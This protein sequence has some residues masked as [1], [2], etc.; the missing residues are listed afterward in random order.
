MKHLKQIATG[1]CMVY[2]LSFVSAYAQ[3]AEDVLMKSESLLLEEERQLKVNRRV[4]EIISSFEDLIRDLRSNGLVKEARGDELLRLLGL[5]GTTNT[6]NVLAAAEHLRGARQNLANPVKFLGSADTEIEII[7]AKL[8]SVLQ[9]S[10]SLQKT[11]ELLNQIRRIIRNQE[12]VYAKSKFIG[13]QLLIGERTTR[14]WDLTKGQLQV[15]MSVKRFGANLAAAKK[16]AKEPLNRLRL[17]RALAVMNREKLDRKLLD[18]TRKIKTKRVVSA[19]RI[20]E[21]ALVSLK[22]IERRLQ[23]NAES[24]ELHRLK[25]AR[26]KLLRIREDQHTIQGETRKATA[27]AFPER[28]KDL[29]VNQRQLQH[30]LKDLHTSIP[31]TK[32]EKL[33]PN[34]HRNTPLDKSLDNAHATM[35]TSEK[36]IEETKQTEAVASQVETDQH[37]GEALLLLDER[38][39]R[40]QEEAL[41]DPTLVDRLREIEQYEKEILDETQVRQKENANVAEIAPAQKKLQEY[42]LELDG[43]I[44]DDALKRVISLS[45]DAMVRAAVSLAANEHDKAI[46]NEKETLTLLARAIEM[47]IELEKE[48]EEVETQEEEFAQEEQAIEQEMDQAEDLID[49]LLAIERL[50]REL[51]EDTEAADANVPE[52]RDLAEPQNDLAKETQR[53][54]ELTDSVP[55]LSAIDD[56]ALAM[57]EAIEKIRESEKELAHAAQLKALEALRKARE[58]AEEKL[59]DLELERDQMQRVDDAHEMAAALKE[60]ERLQKELTIETKEQAAKG[61]SVE[62]IAEPQEALAE[63]VNNLEQQAQNP[64]LEAALEEAV[65]AMERAGGLLTNN[66]PEVAEPNQKQ[67]EEAL[68]RARK[69]AEDAA[70]ELNRQLEQARELGKAKEEA[71]ALIEQQEEVL[72]ETENA[73]EEELADLAAEEEALVEGGEALA[74]TAAQVANLTSEAAQAQQSVAEAQEALAA[75]EQA[76]EQGDQAEATAQ[77]QKAIEALQEAAEQLGE[78]QEALQDPEQAIA[79]RIGQIIREQ[80]GL[81]SETQ[82]AGDSGE[83]AEG[84][85][86]SQS[87]LGE[88]SEQV[89]AATTE[90]GVQESLGEASSAQESASESLEGGD[91]QAAGEAQG[92]ALEALGEALGQAEAAAGEGEGEGEGE[93]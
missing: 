33:V 74:E 89:G 2:L 93:G 30:E 29:Q 86:E 25:M 40:L 10:S 14:L 27:E 61:R 65:G 75:A 56:A 66:L 1:L 87:E 70:I 63:H 12:N 38:I 55:V 36:L 31:R 17:A 26:E 68:A 4:D 60:A 44:E 23:P 34:L 39:A 91:T 50:Q 84:T 92:E 53:A 42:L 64:G 3:D 85:A 8:E 77:E 7:I 19:V 5:L 45:G 13:K 49:R 9:R 58:E 73:P 15:S 62:D 11:T 37:L 16:E 79:E 46:D 59:D 83:S 82:E 47:A 22:D 57:N 24:A 67:A 52:F 54:K 32:V 21:D 48:A 18:A 80:E 35:V 72:D 78:A 81:Q 90:A 76:L 71:E 88:Q 20:Q 43:A 69:L 51:A 6:E 28:K 41:K